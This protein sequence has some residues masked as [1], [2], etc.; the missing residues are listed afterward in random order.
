MEAQPK[1]IQLYTTLDDKIPFEDWLN[2]LRD[3]QARAKIKI[4][5]DRVEEGNFGDC[6]SVGQGV[7]ELRINYGQGYRVYFGQVGITIVILLCGGDK[8][9]QEKDIRKAQEYWQDYKKR[10]NVN[11]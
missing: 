5:L 9:T 2:S 11:N 7:F 1:E 3:S 10:E 8:S 4:R 6:K